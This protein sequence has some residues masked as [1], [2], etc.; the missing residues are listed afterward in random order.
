MICSLLQA[1]VLVGRGGRNTCP[2]SAVVVGSGDGAVC[3][4]CSKEFLGRN[5][6]QNLAHHLLTHTGTRPFHCTHCSYRATQKAHLKRHLER[7]HGLQ[8]QDTPAGLSCYSR[9]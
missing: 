3:P 9:Q 1:V 4:V 8:I 2:D 7:R 6:R 5:R